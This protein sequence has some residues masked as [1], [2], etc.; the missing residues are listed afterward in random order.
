MTPPTSESSAWLLNVSPDEMRRI[1][2]AL[3]RV[4]RLIAAI[5]DLDVLL[6]RIMEESQSA[7][8][9]EACS[10]ILYDN[11]ANEL[12]FQV[13]LGDQGDQQTLKNVIRLKMGQGIAG[14]CALHRQT[15]NVQDVQSDPRFFREAD[16]QTQF[17]TRSVL[18]VPMVDREELVGV[19]EVINKAGS[20]GFDECDVHILEI[21]SSLAATAIVNARLIEEKL[22]AQRLAAIGQAVAGLS[23]YTKNLV[24]GLSASVELIDQGFSSDNYEV[25]RRTWPV[26]KRS[27]RRVSNFVEDML[28]YS[29]ERQPHR[30]PVKVAELLNDAAE[31][32][33][34]LLA[35]KQVQLHIDVQRGD[36]TAEV[37]RDAV[38]RG[39]LNLL[40]NAAD[41]APLKDGTI[42]ARALQEDHTLVFEVSDNG[43][44][45]PPH[46][47]QSIFDPF[48]STKGS[49]G[50]GLGLAVTKKIV[51]EHGGRLE[52]DDNEHGGARFRIYLPLTEQTEDSLGQ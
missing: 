42:W 5:G 43:P 36:L 37:D 28:A 27:T 4:H 13:A 51:D 22:D 38:Y 3:Y 25:L 19:I 26:F 15:I 47:R 11:E 31:T 41:A 33:W 39:L 29:K 12:Y 18:A 52:L 30:E 1:I 24:T 10:L 23:H 50:T 8:E 35:R 6:E 17:Q 9:A 34:G 40:T 16:E 48:F 49:K 45:V 32:F 2:D 21:F 20:S 44:G 14:H 46:I 7:A